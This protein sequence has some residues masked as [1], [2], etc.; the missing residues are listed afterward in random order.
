MRRQV[1]AWGYFYALARLAIA[2]HSLL[3]E[4][5]CPM[6]LRSIYLF[7]KAVSTIN[8]NVDATK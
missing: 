3:T 1:G 4:V 5:D 8:N 2:P 7:D 6:V